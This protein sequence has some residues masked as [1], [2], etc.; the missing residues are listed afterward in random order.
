MT[1]QGLLFFFILM[2]FDK[3][4]VCGLGCVKSLFC[5]YTFIVLSLGF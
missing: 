4:W 3:Y 5:T 2:F 1:S